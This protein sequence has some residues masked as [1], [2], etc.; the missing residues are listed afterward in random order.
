M[1]PTSTLE[2]V[3]AEMIKQMRAQGITL[4]QAQQQL[5]NAVGMATD[6]IRRDVEDGKLK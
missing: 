4:L 2:L 3:K 1:T 6:A 5:S